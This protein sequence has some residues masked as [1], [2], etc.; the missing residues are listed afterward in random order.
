ML[1]W[2]QIF[3]LILLGAIFWVAATAYIRLLPSALVDPVQGPVGFLA[4]FPIA[5]ASVWLTKVIGK[6]KPAQLV[7]GVAV[8]C[9]F[10]MMVDGA[11]LRWFPS[12]YALNDLVLRLGAAWLLWG[13]GLSL[14]I[15]CWIAPRAK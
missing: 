15:A 6:L 2:N 1:K 7:P 13:Y 10:A 5:W 3:I 11:A 8:V 9:A 12:V 4:T 14:A